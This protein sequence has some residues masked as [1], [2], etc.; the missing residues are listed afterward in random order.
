MS[1]FEAMYQISAV[2]GHVTTKYKKKSGRHYFLLQ[3]DNKNWGL[4]CNSYKLLHD[5]RVIHCIQ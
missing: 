2:I 1:E 3:E 5:E 4:C